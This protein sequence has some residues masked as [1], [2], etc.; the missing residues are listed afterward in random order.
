M[1]IVNE[2]IDGKY[3]AVISKFKHLPK[4]IPYWFTC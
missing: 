3:G 4:G 1:E 2:K